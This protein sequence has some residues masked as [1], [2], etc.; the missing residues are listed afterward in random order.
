MTVSTRSAYRTI[1][2]EA[3]SPLCI[4]RRFPI[5]SLFFEFVAGRTLLQNP[6]MDVAGQGSP[7]LRIPLYRSL[8][9]VFPRIRLLCQR[10]G[11]RGMKRCPSEDPALHSPSPCL[12]QSLS[13]LS[14]ALAE[15][16]KQNGAAFNSRLAPVF[17][18]KTFPSFR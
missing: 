17:F 3:I 2:L 14:S 4:S 6:S 12:S 10:F 13:S 16:G 9:P 1:S 11:R 18:H 15:R 8:F 5:G 7:T